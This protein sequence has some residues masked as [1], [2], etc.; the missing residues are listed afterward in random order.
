[1]GVNLLAAHLSSPTQEAGC[2]PRLEVAIGEAPGEVVVRIAG[3]AG[4]AQAS[5]LATALLGLTAR[6]PPL[7]TLDLNA[8]SSVSCLALGVLTAFRRAIVRAGG[9]VRLAAAL[10]EPVRGALVRAGLLLE[11]ER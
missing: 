1:M 11:G 8:L 5:E 2:V 6:R 9:Q 3:E 10:Q 7:V 4:I